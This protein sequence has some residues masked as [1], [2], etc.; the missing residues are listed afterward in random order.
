MTELTPKV[1]AYLGHKEGLTTEAYK[2]S[3]G[4]WTWG[5]GVTNSSGHNVDRYK[6]RPS[7]L[8]EAIDISVWL[9]KEKY[10]PTVQKAFPDL[11][12]AQTAAAL[13]FHWNT[14]A[15]AKVAGNFSKAVQWKRPAVL[16]ARREEEQNLFF[17]G[18]WPKNL[19]VPLYPVNKPSYAPAFGKA[20]LIDITA[21]IKI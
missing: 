18:I 17:K 4:V 6:D 3:V 19:F 1:I 13:S 5:L 10:F 12:E 15:I 7:Q 14:G 20:K 11:N 8:Q 21:L 9:I 2:D 16:A